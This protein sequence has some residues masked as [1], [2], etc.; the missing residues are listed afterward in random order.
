MKKNKILIVAAHADDEVLGCGGTIARYSEK[1]SEVHILII[2]DGESSRDMKKKDL[3]K[4]IR[5]RKK[6]CKIS[7]EILGAKIP[8]FCDFPDNQLDKIPRIKIIKKIEKYVKKIKPEIVFTHHWGDLNID[9]AKVNSAVVTACRPQKGNPVK[10]LLFFEIPSSTEWQISSKKNSF[11]PN[12][13]VDISS[14]I[15]KKI[16]ALKLYKDELKNWPHPRSIKGV[17]S[18]AQW[19]G[20]TVGFKSAEAFVLGRKYE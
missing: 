3:V 12:W 11:S 6:I 14:Q 19:R 2:S 16:K 7:S 1:G 13:Y 4:K 15:E 10:T 8:K 20:A 9:H 5:D 17:L 18:L